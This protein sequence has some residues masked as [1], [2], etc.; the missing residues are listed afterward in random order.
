ML[1]DYE[2]QETRLQKQSATSCSI[3]QWILNTLK[4][5][6]EGG[7]LTAQESQ[8]KYWRRASVWKMAD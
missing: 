1:D 8:K 7:T 4:K 6:I 5:V 3:H 2:S